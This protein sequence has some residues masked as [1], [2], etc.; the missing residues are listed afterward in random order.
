M[1]N[2]LELWHNSACDDLAVFVQRIHCECARLVSGAMVEPKREQSL[3]FV[4]IW[5]SR[6]FDA[7]VHDA[8][9]DGHLDQASQKSSIFHIRH[10][11]LSH[12]EYFDRCR[13]LDVRK[14]SECR[15]EYG[16]RRVRHHNVVFGVW[17]C[18]RY[19][20]VNRLLFGRFVVCQC[21][22]QTMVSMVAG[23]TFHSTSHQR[24][25]IFIKCSMLLLVKFLQW[26]K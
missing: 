18:C 24:V 7:Q 16:H 13:D 12:F 23:V 9:V 25:K 22:S 20:L 4:L 5:I 8:A 19:F 2:M 15:H 3:W 10:G 14:E 6:L 21:P 17:R 11:R 1:P 26:K